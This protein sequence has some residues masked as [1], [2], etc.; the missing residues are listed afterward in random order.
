MS[1]ANAD[2]DFVLLCVWLC[3]CAL[4]LQGRVPDYHTGPALYSSLPLRLGMPSSAVHVV[5]L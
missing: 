2:A 4:L 3:L 5:W 1:S